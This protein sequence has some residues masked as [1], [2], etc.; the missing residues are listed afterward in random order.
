MQNAYEKGSAQEVIWLIDQYKAS[1]EPKKDPE[2]SSKV[3]EGKKKKLEDLSA[4]EARKEA[5]FSPKAKEGDS[6]SFEAG[7][8]ASAGKK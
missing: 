4:V 2:P 8:E 6:D 5:S 7:F 3:K 1:K